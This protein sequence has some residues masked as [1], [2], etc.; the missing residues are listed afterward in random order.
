MKKILISLFCLFSILPVFAQTVQ[1][2]LA[3]KFD[4]RLA[5]FGQFGFSPGENIFF[6]IDDGQKLTVWETKSRA[7][8]YSLTGKFA[9][10]NF[11]PDGEW[12]AV[13]SKKE[14]TI[15][16][17]ESGKI[18]AKSGTYKDEIKFL[19]WNPN[20]KNFAVGTKNFTVDILNVETGEIKNSAVI[21]EKKKGFFGRLN[22]DADFIWIKATFTP[23]GSK[24]L[25]VCQDPTAEIWDVVTGKLIQTFTLKLEPPYQGALPKLPGIYYAEISS[26]GRWILI[27]SYDQ[28][29]LWE[30]ETGKL[31]KEISGYSHPSFS[32]DNRYLGMI[33][34]S[35]SKERATALFDLSTKEIKTI[36]A[37]YNGEMVAWSSDGNMFITDRTTDEMNK[38]VAYIWDAETGKQKATLKTYSKG[39]LDFVSTCLSDFDIF[40]FSPNSQILMSQNKKQVRLL[41][42]ENG[43]KIL[44]LDGAISPAV[45]SSRG[46]F[47]LAKD[48]E[49]GKIGL[50]QVSA[51]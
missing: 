22:D 44:S 18:Q 25:T 38:N 34:D 15:L 23:D 24:I 51:K 43:N 6:A 40:R 47:V 16:T 36:S 48:V 37:K 35:T 2:K 13:F 17:A 10:A 46:N 12:L 7:Q 31:V 3:A 33:T 45:W 4:A 39:C 42:S 9:G 1:T 11:S 50:W 29:R 26:D 19:G 21:H 32:P 30:T 20:S 8:K 5:D 28:N 49:K 14:I 41:N 27:G